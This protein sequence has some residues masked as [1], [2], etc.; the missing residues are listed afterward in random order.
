[1]LDTLRSNKTVFKERADDAAK[2]KQNKKT[3]K[4]KPKTTAAI[5]EISASLMMLL[6]F[7]EFDV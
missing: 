4:L 6:T 3:P 1:M 7:E 5:D 2:T